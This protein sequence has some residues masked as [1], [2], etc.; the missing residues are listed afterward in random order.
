MVDDGDVNDDEDVD[1]DEDDEDEELIEFIILCYKTKVKSTSVQKFRVHCTQLQ[2]MLEV[3]YISICYL[4]DKLKHDFAFVSV[5][6]KNCKLYQFSNVKT[7][8]YVSDDCARQH[9]NF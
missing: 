2:F 3:K 5:L 4:S 8:H 9:K 6:Q 1:D 7:I